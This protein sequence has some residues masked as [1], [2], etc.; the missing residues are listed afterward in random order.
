MEDIKGQILNAYLEIC[1]NEGIELLSFQ[2]IA[3]HTV[4]A[5]TTVRYHLQLQGMTLS[6]V[7]INYVSEKNFEF[8]EQGLLNA[9]KNSQFD[10]LLSYIE[11]MFDWLEKEPLQSNFLV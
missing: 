3:N 9:R 4:V 6:Q 5:L 10:P 1:R 11:I 2:K 8:L 7:A